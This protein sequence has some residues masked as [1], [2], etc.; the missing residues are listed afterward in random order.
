MPQTP[1]AAPVA[2]PPPASQREVPDTVPSAP[3]G[4]VSGAT[5]K[6]AGEKPVREKHAKKAK[7]KRKVV[8]GDTRRHQPELTLPMTGI[9]PAFAYTGAGAA[10]TGGVLAWYA[11]LWPGRRTE[12]FPSRE[13]TRT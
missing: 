7:K 9:S 8:A 4:A 3:R 13:R 2:P 1:G 5:K 6:S 10:V 12:S 11:L